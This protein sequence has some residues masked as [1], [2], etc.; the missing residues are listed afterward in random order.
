[1]Y[2]RQVKR[3]ALDALGSQLSANHYVIKKDYEKVVRY[4]NR[5]L[6]DDA[7]PELE[8]CIRD[9]SYVEPSVRAPISESTWNKAMKMGICKS[10]GR[11]PARGLNFTS[12]S[13][14]YTH[15]KAAMWS[16]GCSY[17]PWLRL[18]CSD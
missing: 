7:P 13:V 1:M 11:Q 15:L 6:K 18:L 3:A 4:K 5:L 2:K 12:A 9:S 14:S 16:A 10:M 17:L 8:M